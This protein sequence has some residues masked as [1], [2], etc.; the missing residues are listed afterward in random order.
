MS[1]SG[2]AGPVR[3]QPADAAAGEAD[4]QA[5]ESLVEAIDS[6]IAANAH[7]PP[8][9]PVRDDW[10]DA[11]ARLAG[12]GRELSRVLVVGVIGGT[13]TGKSTLVNALAGAEV[14]PAGDISRPT[15][16]SPVV[17]AAEATDCSWLPL[18]DWDAR[19]V[20]TASPAIAGVVLV[21]CPDPDTQDERADL[22]TGPRGE[23]PPNRNR[24]ILESVLP[25]CDVLLLVS[26]AQKYRSWAV[27]RE[28]VRF[29][30]G[31][32]LL[33]V[34]THA[35]RDPDIR[36]DWKRALSDDGFD[37]PVMHRLDGV[38][39]IRRAREGLPPEPGFAELCVSI[40]TELAGRA[41]VRVRRTGAIDLLDWF[42]RRTTA[43]LAGVR[44]PVAALER[45][46]ADERARLEAVLAGR[47]AGQLVAASGHWQRLLAREL[48][49]EGRGGPFGVFL[50]LVDRLA[51]AWPGLA[52]GGSGLV[53][54]AL[55]GR[56]VSD[57]A[58]DETGGGASP[59]MAAIREVGLTE[60][61]VEQ[62]RSI[63]VGLAARARIEEP[64]V[65]RARLPE[66]RAAAIV[67]EVLS[68][69]G[70]WLDEGIGRLVEARRD[71]LGTRAGRWT[72][73]VAFCGFVLAVVGRAAWGFFHDRL[74]AGQPSAGGGLLWEAI[75][76]ILLWGFFLRWV[77]G[78]WI[79]RGL[80]GDVR[81][82]V[83]GLPQAHLVDPILEDFAAAA[84]EASSALAA[85]E[86]LVRR[87]G[88]LAAIR[89]D[90]A[91]G[92]GRLRGQSGPVGRGIADPPI[93]AGSP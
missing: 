28:V 68:R 82:L 52:A 40:Q 18:A 45:G 65:G 62:S 25:S 26:T 81:T 59:G 1:G 54:R 46:I 38:E 36:D 16:K 32:P 73:E 86:G 58:A 69:A 71:R 2:T 49:G 12:V 93:A 76:W 8:L 64:Q 7:W 72:L 63:L 70:R 34:Q 56:P 37:V 9:R 47:L 75:P 3:S 50:S 19:V 10:S 44:D 24:E 13:G 88:S 48:T 43:R 27:A 67:A 60:A 35:S 84:R 51:G 83:T 29:A 21:D 33:F 89:T 11:G 61:D 6:W 92:L 42:L 91:G 31:R 77:S 55:A 90:A 39:A 57:A 66:A 14:S 53:G 22:R 4:A 17:V 15:T 79:R 41:A 80:E 23:E 87:A 78:A 74:W 20:R 30:P 85:F 5:F